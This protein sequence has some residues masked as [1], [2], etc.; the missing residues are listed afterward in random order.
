[1]FPFVEDAP[2]AVQFIMLVACAIMG[3]SHI[4]RPAMWVEFFTHLHAQGVRGVVMKTFMLELWP[5]LLIVAL[6]QVWWGPGIVLTLYGWAQ[7]TK[8][9]VAMLAPE[10]GL[11]SMAMAQKGDRAFVLGGVMLLVVGAFAGAALFWPG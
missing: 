10:I 2:S 3:M 5:A 6:H 1:M 8:V 4:V 11:R 7:L 9:T